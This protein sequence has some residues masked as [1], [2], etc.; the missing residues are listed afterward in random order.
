[1]TRW[2][3]QRGRALPMAGAMI[4]AMAIPLALAAQ[5]RP[6]PPAPAGPAATAVTFTDVTASAGITFRHGNGAFGRKY[7]PETMGSGVAFLDIDA[8]GWQDVF[9]VNATRFPGRPEAA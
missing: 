1:M 7:L 4:C 6:A 8:D 2:K 9:F 3:R 5:N